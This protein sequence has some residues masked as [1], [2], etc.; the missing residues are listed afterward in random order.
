MFILERIEAGRRL[1]ERVA[2]RK[3]LRPVVLVIPPGGVLPG[4]EIAR[5][6]KAPIDVIS[7]SEVVVPGERAVR[8]GAVS[9]GAFV[10]VREKLPAGLDRNGEYVR[11]LVDL[12][13]GRQ[14]AQDQAYRDRMPRLNIAQRDVILVDD[15]WATPDMIQAAVEGIRRRGPSSILYASAQCQTEAAE[16][17]GSDVTQESLYA[18]QPYRTILL[19]DGAAGKVTVA[20]ASAL[21]RKSRLIAE[22]QGEPLMKAMP[23]PRA[24]S[25]A[26]N[27]ALSHA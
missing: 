25:H 14:V 26:S 24:A 15:G 12:E 13:I 1:A 6:L 18:W 22:I 5:T 3:L 16:R 23:G 2:G 17:C 21:I 27:V 10:A 7:V 20:E 8:L 9:D 11:R 19:T 4:W